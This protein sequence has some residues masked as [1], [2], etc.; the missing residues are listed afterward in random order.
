MIDIKKVRADIRET[1]KIVNDHAIF[2]SKKLKDAAT[3]AAEAEGYSPDEWI[4]IC[5]KATLEAI[6]DGYH[7]HIDDPSIRYPEH[8]ISVAPQIEKL[9]AE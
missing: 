2:I 9:L 1:T 5:V 4:E 6:V 3:L 7:A 8:L